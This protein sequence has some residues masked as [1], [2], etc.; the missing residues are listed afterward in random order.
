MCSANWTNILGDTVYSTSL[1]SSGATLSG[2]FYKIGSNGQWISVN[3]TGIVTQIGFCTTSTFA[4]S[5]KELQN[6]V[7]C[8]LDID[9]TYYFSGAGTTPVATNYCYSDSGI[10][11]LANG[12]YRI[13]STQYIV[14]TGGLGQVSGVANC[15]ALVYYPFNTELQ[16]S[17]QAACLYTHGLNDVYYTTSGTGPSDGAGT[18]IYSD[19]IGTLVTAQVFMYS[20]APNKFFAT[21]GTGA[22]DANGI[23]NC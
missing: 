10:T 2:G 18:L 19:Q 22:I 21:D 3:T 4:S 17:P 5:V 1:C 7:V 8:T 15:Q 14:I 12:L 6:A 9:Q 23:Q 20:V 13:S 11:P 16:I